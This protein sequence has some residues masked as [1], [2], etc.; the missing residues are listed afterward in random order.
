[1]P[2]RT[3]VAYSSISTSAFWLQVN[4][5]CC[6]TSIAELAGQTS[7]ARLGNNLSSHPFCRPPLPFSA[8]SPCISTKPITSHHYLSLYNIGFLLTWHRLTSRAQLALLGL[9]PYV[10][11]KAWQA[12][13]SRFRPGHFTPISHATAVATGSQPRESQHSQPTSS[14]LSRE[15]DGDDHRSITK[16]T[17]ARTTA[18]THFG[19]RGRLLHPASAPAVPLSSVSTVYQA[20]LKTYSS[21]KHRFPLFP[22]QFPARRGQTLSF[23]VHRLGPTF[24]L[25]RRTQQTG[26]LPQSQQL[27]LP[28]PIPESRRSGDPFPAQG[29]AYSQEQVPRR[30]VPGLRRRQGV[31]DLANSAS[32][33]ATARPRSPPFDLTLPTENELL[34]AAQHSLSTPSTPLV[35]RAAVSYRKNRPFTSSELR[36]GEQRITTAPVW[37]PQ[38]IPSARRRRPTF[39]PGSDLSF[40]A[41]NRSSSP[42]P[43]LSGITTSSSTTSEALTSAQEQGSRAAD[44]FD[45]QRPGIFDYFPV[46]SHSPSDHQSS[47]SPLAAFDFGFGKKDTEGPAK[48]H[49]RDHGANSTNPAETHPNLDNFNFSFPPSEST[50]EEPPEE[51]SLPPLPSKITGRAPRGLSSAIAQAC[52]KFEPES[53]SARA[54]AISTERPTKAVEDV[55]FPRL[56]LPNSRRLS[57][58]VIESERGGPAFSEVARGKRSELRE[59]SPSRCDF[60]EDMDFLNP[61]SAMAMTGHRR[62]A[63]RMAKSQEATVVEKC[64]RSGAAAPCYTFDELIGKGSFGR[65]YKG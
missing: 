55:G 59:P 54:K 30:R 43:P 44:S 4:T 7:A 16:L 31:F 8:S 45:P 42:D 19:A 63:V 62:E 1:M 17:T 60:S 26:N 49:Q 41:E 15:D 53:D 5:A 27:D 35:R 52:C 32:A 13:R 2:C 18:P 34:V 12:D 21:S 39:T 3:H 9:G 20:M 6:Q 33:A 48:S 23:V 50:P 46:D 47:S 24:P 51:L 40:C 36:Q 14:L 10:H 65:V 38:S 11:L 56:E 28:R 64:K 22:R 37:T 61:E 29:E 58:G 57:L 25:I